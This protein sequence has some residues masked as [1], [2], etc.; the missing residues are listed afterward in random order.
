MNEIPVLGRPALRRLVVRGLTAGAAA[1]VVLPTV[2]AVALTGIDLVKRRGRK[3]RPAQ[4]PGTFHVE[5]GES[6]VSIFTSGEELFEAM[7]AA[8]DDARESVK[9]ETY[10]W[11][12]DETGQRFM[13][14]VNRAAERGVR[15]WISYDGF[16]NLVVSPRFYRQFHPAVQ[17]YRMP[18]FTRPYWR[19]IV[20]HTGFNHSKILVVDHEVGFVG[21]YNIG[22]DYAHHWRDTHVRQVGPAVWG[23]DHS[24]ATVWN[25]GHAPE[26][27]MEWHTPDSWNQAVTVASNLPIQLVYPVRRVY[28]EAIERARDHIY[29]NTPYFIPDQ[30]ILEALKDAARRG[31]DVQV[32]LPKDSNHV[33]ADW[34]SRGF[35]AEMLEA[36]ITVLLYRASMIHA[37][38][39]TV[40]G[41]WGTVGTANIDRLS[42]GYNYETNLSVVGAEFAARM[43][44]IFRADAAHCD[45]V[46][47][48]RWKDRHGIARVVETLLVP[49]RPLL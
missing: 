7:I 28:L 16:A 30:Q 36:G 26:E 19:G 9:L 24:I 32:M 43:E 38:T 25:A 49:L 31:V 48:P 13:D 27:R 4:R 22:D 3:Q 17:V 6:S 35:Y 41:E 11:K 21:G 8:I 39:A 20:R 34:V 10:I 12:G 29:I 42:L 33:V 37:K 18:A 15:V 40:D 45:V 14:A 5:A 47:S 44:E 1:L 2:T 46:T 23:L